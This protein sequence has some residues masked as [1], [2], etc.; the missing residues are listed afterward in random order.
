MVILRWDG[1]FLQIWTKDARIAFMNQREQAIQTWLQ[2]A[3]PSASPP[4]LL[5]GDASFRRYFRVH[6][7]ASDF[8]LMDA[9]PGKE[10]CVAFVAI[11][12]TLRALGLHAPEVYRAD[13]GQGF[14]LLTDFGN[15]QLL[16]FLNPETV[17]RCYHRAFDYLLTMQSCKQVEGYR[18]PFFNESLCKKELSLFRDWYLGRHLER[19]LSASDKQYL[20]K[21]DALLV[22]DA[23]SQPQVFVH[24]DYHSRNLMVLDDDAFG[25]LDFQDAVRG[26]IT[27]DLMSLLRDCYI[28]WPFEQVKVWILNYHQRL[29]NAGYL[30]EDNP[31]QFLRWCDWMA[32]QR[33]LKCIGIFSRLHYRDHRSAYLHDIP[34]LISYVKLICQRYPEFAGLEKFLAEGK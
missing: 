31:K 20:D 12:K 29:L 23:L 16:N 7:E 10:S 18:L 6:S 22:E 30:S 5:A 11:A 19:G 9:P 14:L 8:V 26:P 25:I 15:R 27:Y 32:L 1:Q 3:C 21:V 34:R 33:H 28:E 24:R 4:V 13:L 17:D 2:T